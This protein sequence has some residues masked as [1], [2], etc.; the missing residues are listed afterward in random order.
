M[1]KRNIVYLSGPITGVEHASARMFAAAQSE[2]EAKGYAVV[3][4][5]NLAHAHDRSWEWYM[6]VDIL[7]MLECH[8]I[9]LLPN[10]HKSRGARLEH[11]I[12]QQRGMACMYWF[13]RVEQLTTAGEQCAF[14]DNL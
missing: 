11:A 2:L 7:A 4:P 14:G 9:C 3:N 5:M 12:A 8:I 1:S 6:A 10:W 13:E